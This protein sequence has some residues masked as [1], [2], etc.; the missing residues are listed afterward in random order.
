MGEWCVCLKLAT[1]ALDLMSPDGPVPVQG[2]HRDGG[3]SY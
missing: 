2:F 3:G 1:E